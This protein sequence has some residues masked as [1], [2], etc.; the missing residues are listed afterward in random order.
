MNGYKYIIMDKTLNFRK[1]DKYENKWMQKCKYI[2]KNLIKEDQMAH[3]LGKKYYQEC[4][5]S[6]R[7]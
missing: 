4:H 5:F 6:K 2:N 3:F 7:I 1:I